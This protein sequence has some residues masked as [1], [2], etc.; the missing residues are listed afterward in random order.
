[1]PTVAIDL[2][3]H[4][5]DSARCASCLAKKLDSMKYDENQGSTAERSY[6]KGWNDALVNVIAEL[7][8]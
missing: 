1:M 6:R 5:R 4:D 3:H 7:K 2:C 8:K